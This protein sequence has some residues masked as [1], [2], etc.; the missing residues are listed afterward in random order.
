MNIVKA[1]VDALRGHPEKLADKQP[2][3]AAEGSAA[4]L[5]PRYAAY[6]REAQGMG[7]T[8]VSREEFHRQGR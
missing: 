6:V 1:L 7:E 3:V 5:D 4:G 2:N 8:P